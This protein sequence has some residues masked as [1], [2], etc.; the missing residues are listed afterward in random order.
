[1]Q[2]LVGGSSICLC[3]CLYFLSI[4]LIYIC[5][6]IYISTYYLCMVSMYG[7][8]AT[9]RWEFE[10]PSELSYFYMSNIYPSIHP[11]NYP[12]IYKYIYVGLSG[13]PQRWEGDVPVQLRRRQQQRDQRGGRTNPRDHILY[14]ACC[15]LYT[16]GVGMHYESVLYT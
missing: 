8:Y 15:T 9:T 16:V 13:L 3:L 2:A 14:I 6:Y 12:I 10:I 4:F 5:I 7:I 11:S 1:M